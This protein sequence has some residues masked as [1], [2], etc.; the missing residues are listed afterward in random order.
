[1]TLSWAHRADYG[2]LPI[3]RHSPSHRQNL[4]EQTFSELPDDFLNTSRS[5]QAESFTNPRTG[6]FASSFTVD[7]FPM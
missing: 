4:K 7:E 5:T 6:L 2:V 3:S 1:M